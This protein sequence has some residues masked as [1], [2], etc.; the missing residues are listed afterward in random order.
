MDPLGLEG[1]NPD[2]SA[3]VTV[4]T[5]DGVH[6]GHREIV[7]S[8]VGISAETGGTS[9]VVTFD[10]HPREVTTGNL[11][12]LLSTVEER[13]ALLRAL[14]VARTIVIPFTRAFATMSP[15]EF[16][17]DVIAGRVGCRVMVTGYDHAFGQGR[18]GDNTV[19]REAGER[20]GFSVETVPPFLLDDAPVSSTAIRDHLMAD[21][22]VREATRLLGRRYSVGGSV[23]RGDGRGRSIGY[24]TANLE[25]SSTRKV[26]PARGVYAVVV[27]VRGSAPLVGMMN[28]GVRPTF[29][30]TK[31]HLE[32]HILDFDESIY[33]ESLH[34]EFVDRLRDETRFGSVEDLVRQL[35]EDERRCR[36]AVGAVSLRPYLDG[37]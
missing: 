15:T 33:G 14:G 32:V 4:G 10:P 9:T 30:G 20:L 22:N 28:I 1:L 26:I 34:I 27:G 12:P 24:P 3:I 6:L 11:V 16:V 5:F 13:L 37:L 35:N 31:V 2:S 18:S 25:V 17:A 8:V 29:G 7:R 36:D 19:L 21:G 23:V